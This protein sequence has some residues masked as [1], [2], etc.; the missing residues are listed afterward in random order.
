MPS[1]R[2]APMAT[3]TIPDAH[4][5]HM[6]E[7]IYQALRHDIAFGRLMPRQRLVES[8]LCVR[9]GTTNHNV[10]LAFE[11]LD[12]VGL[13][14]RKANRGVE[15]KALSAQ[16]LMNLY[17]V[18]VM[19]QR[20][21]A[22]SLDMSRREELV[23][24]LSAINADYEKALDEDRLEAAAEANDAFHALL[25]DYCRNAELAKLQR[26]YWLNAS[27]IISRAL[28]DRSLS[29][30]SRKDHH[31]IIAAISAGDVERLIEVTVGHIRP[32]VDVYRRLYGLF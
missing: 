9:F 27:A 5:P 7:V 19:L 1:T 17:E 23:A 2:K 11:L 8:D 24:Q 14:E 4:K 13:I 18:R 25:F 20:E 15:V 3:E 26:S 12:R 22:R 10:R 32:A 6:A 28:T 29:Q 16:E 21:G 30:N 31:E